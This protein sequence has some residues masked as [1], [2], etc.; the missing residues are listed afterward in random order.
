MRVSLAEFDE[1]IRTARWSSEHE[2]QNVCEIL[3]LLGYQGL[4]SVGVDRI[5]LEVDSKHVVMP[6]SVCEL[7][8]PSSI[9]REIERCLSG[10]GAHYFYLED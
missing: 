4:I 8:L 10:K 3:R 9:K 6:A 5:T 1:K 2:A 7:L